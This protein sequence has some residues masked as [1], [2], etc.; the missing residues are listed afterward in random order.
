M[1]I[2][3]YCSG[4]GRHTLCAL[5]TGV[6]TCALPICSSALDIPM[7][8]VSARLMS[9]I[10]LFGLLS[11]SLSIGASTHSLWFR[12]CRAINVKIME[13]SFSLISAMLGEIGRAS[14]RERVCQYV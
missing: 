1:W 13:L 12:L 9:F 6:Q 3:V 11:I 8:F 5:V 14:C 10:G 7:A 4:R 2:V